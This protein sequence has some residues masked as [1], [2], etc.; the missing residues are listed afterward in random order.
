MADLNYSKHIRKTYGGDDPREVPLYTIPRASRYLK[1]PQRTIR[2]WVMGWKYQ[3]KGGLAP[4]IKLP[5][6]NV[7]ILSFMNLVEA[8]VLGGM[9]RLENVSFPKVRKGLSFL[10]QQFPSPHPLADQLFETDGVNLFIRKLDH[11]INISQNGQVEMAEVV[12]GY[13]RRIDR[14]ISAGVI[15]LYPFLKKDPSIDEPKRV[16]IDPLI[17]FGRPVLVGTGVPTDV[18]AERFYA[19]DTFDDLARDYEITPTQVEEAVR[20]EGDARKAA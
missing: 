3:T 18:I 9:R 4:V 7:P 19:G 1:I 15:R 14:N 8:H 20:Y 13:L 2:D 6:P 10:E 12:S 17:S 5:K 16:M 11:L